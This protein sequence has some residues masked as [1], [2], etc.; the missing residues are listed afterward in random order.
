MTSKEAQIIAA[1][2]DAAIA[3]GWY[4]CK[5]SGFLFYVPAK[6]TPEVLKIVDD[7]KSVIVNFYSSRDRHAYLCI[8][9]DEP[10]VITN[11]TRTPIFYEAVT[12]AIRKVNELCK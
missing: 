6:T 4:P 1:A 11:I 3:M 8:D 12:N 2:V 9:L 10:D 5:V 7:E